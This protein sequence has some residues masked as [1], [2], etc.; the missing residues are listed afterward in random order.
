VQNV[1]GEDSVLSDVP[2]RG[3]RVRFL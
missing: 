3:D 2:E 1:E